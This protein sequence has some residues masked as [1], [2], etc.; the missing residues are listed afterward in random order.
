L[1]NYIIIILIVIINQILIAQ[2]IDENRKVIVK[3]YSI[4]T[5]ENIYNNQEIIIS[6]NDSIVFFYGLSADNNA[7]KDPFLF[8]LVLKKGQDSSVFI[9]VKV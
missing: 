1:K 9:Q 4:N 7:P 5:T 2:P 3:S 6:N 8:R